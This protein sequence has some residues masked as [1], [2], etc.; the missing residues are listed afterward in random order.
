M[1]FVNWN[2]ILEKI[3]WLLVKLRSLCHVPILFVL[4]LASDRAVFYGSDAF[5]ILILSTKKGHSRFLRRVFVFQR[6]YF[7]V[8]VLKTFRISNDCHIKTCRSL[9]RG[10]INIR[11]GQRQLKKFLYWIEENTVFPDSIVKRYSDV[12]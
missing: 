3:K 12:G 8:K 7:T 6:I 4:T 2:K 9:K 10:A 5:S 1:R 11:K